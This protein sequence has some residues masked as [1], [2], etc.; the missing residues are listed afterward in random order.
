MRIHIISPGFTPEVFV[1]EKNIE[2]APLGR[3]GVDKLVLI[4]TPYPNQ[5]IEK[6]VELVVEKLETHLKMKSTRITLRE[7]TFSKL[8][9]EIRQIIDSFGQGDEI[10]LHL[11]AGERHVVL[12]MAYASFF[13]RRRV[14]LVFATE[15]GSGK[16]D[17]QFEMM[18][19]IPTY[20]LTRKQKEAL[21]L[22][23]DK[24]G[25]TLKE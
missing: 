22:V 17:Y 11:E 6:K 1:D 14:R 18:P 9:N 5:E 25:Q 24:D 2:I 12:A 20:K 16:K 3:I 4:H 10:Y 23:A 15:Y 13:A 7:K 8:I 21:K 19:P